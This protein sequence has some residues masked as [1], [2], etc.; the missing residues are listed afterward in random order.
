MRLDFLLASAALLAGSAAADTLIVGNKLADTVSFVDLGS[1]REVAEL[2]TGE[3]PHEVAVSPD[4]KLA[5]VVAYGGTT[6]DLFDVEKLEKVGTCDL[7]P[8]AAPHGIVWTEAGGVLVT[9]EGSGTLTLVTPDCSRA[10]AIRDR[11]GNEPHGR[12]RRAAR[13]RLCQQ[14]RQPDGD[15]HRPWRRARS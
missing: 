1:G 2:P 11:A 5:F 14:S 7:S 13:P 8:N 6:M 12:R 4:G 3:A 15:G 10:S 9:T